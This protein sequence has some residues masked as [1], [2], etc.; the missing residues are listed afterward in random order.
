MIA[1]LLAALDRL[2][3]RRSAGW[4]TPVMPVA[5]GLY[6]PFGL[7]VTIFIGAILR[8]LTDA[9]RANPRADPACCSPLASSRG[10][11]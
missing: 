7:S 5:I 10:R 2:L 3:E 6:L 8:R 11:P 1:A 9:G 4:R